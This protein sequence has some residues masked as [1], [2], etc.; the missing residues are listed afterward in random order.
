MYVCTYICTYIDICIISGPQIF[1]KSMS[2]LPVPGARRLTWSKFRTED[3]QLWSDQRTSL[4]YGTFCSVHLHRFTFMY[5]R[6]KLQKLWLKYSTHRAKFS[7]PGDQTHGICAPLYITHAKRI[8]TICPLTS[9]VV[10]NLFFY[11]IRDTWNIKQRQ[12]A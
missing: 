8:P 12:S 6:K 1:Y 5:V 10:L 3:L 11:P 9:G 7:R 4:L 2:Q